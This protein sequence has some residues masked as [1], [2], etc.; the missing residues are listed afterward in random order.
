MQQLTDSCLITVITVSNT[1]WPLI[2][3]N[4]L[5]KMRAFVVLVL[6]RVRLLPFGIMFC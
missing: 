1:L 6:Q 5:T 4:L 3:V 2:C